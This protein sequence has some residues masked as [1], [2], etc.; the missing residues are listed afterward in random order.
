MPVVTFSDVARMRLEAISFFLVVFL[1]SAWLIQRI[2]NGLARDFPRL[3]RLSY[4]RALGVTTLWGLLFLLVLSMISGA[5]E[6]MTP[7]AWKKEGL[8]YKLADAA[9]DAPVPSPDDVARRAP[10]ERLR[11]LLLGYAESHEG[12]FPAV[13]AAPEI[14]EDAWRL[15]GPSGLRYVYVGGQKPEASKAPRPLAYEPDLYGAERLVLLTTGDIQV[16]TLAEI[17]AQLGRKGP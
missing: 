10:L 2:W 11:A 13:A 17:Q 3:P 4:W 5:R 9:K 12:A 16:Q 14:P 1:A 6:L 7:G 8:T 15:P